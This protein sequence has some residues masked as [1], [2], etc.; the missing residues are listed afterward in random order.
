[1]I[2]PEITNQQIASLFHKTKNLCNYTHTPMV[3]K[4]LY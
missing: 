2:P 3:L 4:K 1:M